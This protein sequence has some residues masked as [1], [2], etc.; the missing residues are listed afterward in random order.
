MVNVCVVRFG[1][2]TLNDERLD[3][4]RLEL[5]SSLGL[6]AALSVSALL[7]ALC[8]YVAGFVAIVA[9]DL[10]RSAHES[11]YA[12]RCLT[13]VVSPEVMPSSG[14]HSREEGCHVVGFEFA[15]SSPSFS[16]SRIRV[17]S[18]FAFSGLVIHPCRHTSHDGGSAVRSRLQS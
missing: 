4:I 15:S 10:G 11:A 5:S 2:S 7:S 1:R 13:E 8:L 18:F 6:S 12:I 3:V 14:A 9:H 17:V 16:I